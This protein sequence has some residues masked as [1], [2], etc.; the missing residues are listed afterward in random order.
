[1]TERLASVPEPFEATGAQEQL[2]E[3]L[4]PSVALAGGGSLIIQPTAALTAIDVN[5]GGRQ[6]WKPTSPQPVRSP[7]SCA[8]AG[9]A[10]RSWSTSS[11][12]RR[13]RR[14]RACSRRC[15]PPWPMTRPGAGI[16]DVALRP[17][18]D[19]PQTDRAEPGRDARAAVS[20]VRGGRHAA[21]AALARRAA[22]PSLGQAVARKGD[23]PRRAGPARLF[24]RDGQGA[25]EAVANRYGISRVRDPSL[26]PGGHRIEELS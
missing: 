4:Q 12:C 6:A 10:A 16:S 21:G 22:V 17:G 25:W 13:G 8:C 1:M 7:G 18:R 11:I 15:A 3:A 9:S 19:E 24:E 2:E 26:A 23:G 20:G 5:G 14:A